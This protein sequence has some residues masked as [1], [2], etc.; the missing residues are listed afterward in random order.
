M[1]VWFALDRLFGSWIVDTA[2]TPLSGIFYLLFA[3]LSVEPDDIL[4]TLFQ[5]DIFL[6]TFHLIILIII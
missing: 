4:Q 5:K 6:K 2:Y 1:S 3:R